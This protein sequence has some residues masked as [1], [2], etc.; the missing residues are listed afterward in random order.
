MLCQVGMYCY[1]GNEV[2]VHADA[3]AQ[4]AYES[5]WYL[6]PISI[7]KAMIN[8]IQRSHRPVYITAGKF[9]PLS[10]ET[11]MKVI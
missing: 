5:S 11:L 2:T 1:W 9:V 6:M 7:Q 3:V 4:L 8:V 10:M